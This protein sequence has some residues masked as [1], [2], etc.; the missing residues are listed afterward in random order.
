MAALKVDSLSLLETLWEFYECLFTA[1]KHR[2]LKCQLCTP[3]VA[4][5][6]PCLVIGMTV[7]TSL[8]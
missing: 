2:V 4:Y 7:D 3:E 5:V 1:F 8:V 6:H